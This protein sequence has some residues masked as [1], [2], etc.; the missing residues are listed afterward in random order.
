MTIDQYLA[1]MRE[2]VAFQKVVE[3]GKKKDAL[4]GRQSGTG[5]FNIDIPVRFPKTLSRIIGQGANISVSGSES[6]T[7]SGETQYYIKERDKESGGQR[8]FPELD[9]RQQLQINL[10]G[11]IG[12]KF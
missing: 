7:F 5:H 2:A 4:S 12:E 3:R 11:T 9:M 6:I 10:T 1:A 8:K